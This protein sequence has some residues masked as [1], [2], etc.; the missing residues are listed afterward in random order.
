MRQ[1]GL[2]HLRDPIQHGFHP[3]RNQAPVR[4]EQ[5]HRHRCGDEGGQHLGEQAGIDQA[6]RATQRH[7]VRLPAPGLG[8]QYPYMSGLLAAAAVEMALPRRL[9][10]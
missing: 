9:G 2:D 5:R 1:P 8:I 3:R 7:F 10:E 4:V 6:L